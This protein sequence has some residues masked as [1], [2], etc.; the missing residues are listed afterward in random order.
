M[1]MMPVYRAVLHDPTRPL[2][3]PDQ[4]GTLTIPAEPSTT[5]PSIVVVQFWARNVLKMAGIGAVVEIFKT[6]ETLVERM[7]HE[8]T[9]KG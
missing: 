6:E 1:A 9:E 3:E 2:P 7:E 4:Y 5:S 8:P